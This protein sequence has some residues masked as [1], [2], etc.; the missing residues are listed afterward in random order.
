MALGFNGASTVVSLTNAMDLAPNYAPTIAAI[1]NT[2]G[3]LAG[4]LA[5]MLITFFTQEQVN[6]GIH[7]L[8]CSFLQTLLIS[9]SR[10]P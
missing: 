8:F 1:I 6:I 7:S 10:V 4:I 9:F 3:A 2:F 5:P